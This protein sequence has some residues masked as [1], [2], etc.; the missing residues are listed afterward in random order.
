VEQRAPWANWRPASLVLGLSV[1]LL[2]IIFGIFGLL[3]WQAYG[4]IIA[5]AEAKAQSAAD[6]VAAQTPWMT[7][8]AVLALSQIEQ[9]LGG[10]PARA[11]DPALLKTAPALPTLSEIGIYDAAGKAVARSDPSQLPDEI[12]S[13]AFFKALA[14]GSAA[15]LSPQQNGTDG[16]AYFFIAE[17]MTRDGK[18]SGAAVMSISADVLATLWDNLKLG[19]QST[20]SLVRT[21]GWIVARYP[22]LPQ[23]L[24]LSSTP[25][26]KTV[27]EHDSGTYES[28]VSPAD[29]VARVVAYKHIPRLNLITF[30]SVSQDV[31]VSQLWRS[32]W[33]VLLLMGPIALALLGVA[34][35]SA[36]LLTAAERSRAELEEV[37]QHNQV[38]FREIH[39]RVKNNLQA[40][41]SI[42]QLSPT[43]AEV[44]ADIVRRI[45][46]MSAI[47]EHIYRS[48]RFTSVEVEGYLG[49]LA[50]H[51]ANTYGGDNEI[52]THLESMR[53]PHDV[54]MPLG[55]LVNELLSNSLKHAFVDG[56]HGVITVTLTREDEAHALL[57]IEDNGVGFDTT[58]RSRGIGRRLIS[59][60]VAQIDGTSEFTSGPDGSRF[61]LRFAV[62]PEDGET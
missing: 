18:F 55:L 12:G 29:G 51:L 41:A 52:V 14:G 22:P 33:T 49:T 43:P 39:H 25:I 40:V 58:S 59:G 16:K 15:E 60:L 7:G 48:E 6:V 38:L 32:V 26:F 47:H 46:A 28:P 62:L 45:S 8:S 44:K 35:L 42:I 31:V 50:E 54:A 1:G 30:A 53:V 37:L 21:D 13:A 4:Q 2:L 10:D 17:P 56:R 57:L 5:Q 9:S 19:T 23:P 61:T 3:V 20:I 36:R 34:V 11:Q 24:D 27:L